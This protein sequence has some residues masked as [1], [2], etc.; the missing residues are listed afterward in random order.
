MACISSLAHLH[1]GREA[2]CTCGIHVCNKKHLPC[3]KSL[4][5]L[6]HCVK[7]MIPLT[8]VIQALL[9]PVMPAMQ[10]EH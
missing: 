5:L 3:K 4:L 6:G 8:Q 9:H 10:S 2:A 7:C 1:T